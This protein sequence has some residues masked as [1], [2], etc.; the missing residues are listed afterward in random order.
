DSIRRVTSEAI[1]ITRLQAPDP[2]LLPL[3]EPKPVRPVDRFFEVTAGATPADRAHAVK[4]AID[5]VESDS[6]TAAG[7]YST[8]QSALA[9]LNSRGL[10]D[11]HSETMAQFSITALGSAS[12]GWAK[13]SA[14]DAAALDTRALAA[15]A[16]RKAVSSAEPREAPPGR[17]T[18]IL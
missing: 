3:A 5:I 15:D 1:V 8:G 6:L 9:I 11:Y 13:A 7:I 10:F 12:S 14:C 4:S 17:Y 16:A 18:V 2:E